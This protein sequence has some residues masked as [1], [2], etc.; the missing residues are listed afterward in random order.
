[1]RLVLLGCLGAVEEKWQVTV[2]IY[3]NPETGPGDKQVKV[4]GSEWEEPG[5]RGG[6]LCSLINVEKEI[7]GKAY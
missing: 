5:L 6:E 4:M 1:M 3:P 7:Q 2:I